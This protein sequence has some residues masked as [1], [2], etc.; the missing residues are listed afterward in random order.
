MGDQFLEGH[1]FHS[2]FTCKFYPF[3]QIKWVD[4]VCTFLD[5]LASLDLKLSVSESVSN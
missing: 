2:F 4:V 1:G 5:A 3:E